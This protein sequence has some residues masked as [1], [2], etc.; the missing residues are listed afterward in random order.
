MYLSTLLKLKKIIC[1]KKIGRSIFYC[2][3]VILFYVRY[4]GRRKIVFCL[5]VHVRAC[6]FFVESK[7]ENKGE[8]GWL[9][10]FR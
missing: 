7:K 9:H 3:F 5:Y 2:H 4:V 8:E 6:L 10:F 1:E